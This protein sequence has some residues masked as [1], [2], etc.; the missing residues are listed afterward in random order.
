[1]R[2]ASALHDSG[3]LMSV[4]ASNSNVSAPQK[5]N[6]YLLLL[7]V[8]SVRGDAGVLA[9]RPTAGGQRPLRGLLRRPDGEARAEG[10]PHFVRVQRGARQ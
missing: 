9:R 3:T 5:L 2:V 7:A 10:E 8:G 4:A 1:M 6:S